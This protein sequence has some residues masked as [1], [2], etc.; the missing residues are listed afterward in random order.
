MAN[1][2]AQTEAQKTARELEQ[3]ER[4]SKVTEEVAKDARE[5]PEEYLKETVVPA[6]GE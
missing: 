1:V 4:L 3:E 6:G 5:K 2:N